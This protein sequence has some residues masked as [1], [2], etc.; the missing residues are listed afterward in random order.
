LTFDAG[1]EEYPSF[2]PDG[3]TLVFDG[4][5]DGDYELTALDLGSGA[6]RRLTHTRGW[7][8]RAVVSP[9]GRW[10][11]YLHTS[12]AGR[13]LRVLPVA[14]DGAAAPRALGLTAS[15]YPAWSRDG[16]I[17]AGDGERLL[18]WSLD[19][20]ARTVLAEAPAGAM[21]RYAAQFAS[22]AEGGP[23]G[24]VVALADLNDIQVEL[25]IAQDDFAKLGAKQ[26]ATVILDAFKDRSYKG[27]I[28]EISPEANRQ[29]A[30][31]QAFL[32]SI[33]EPLKA[34]IHTVCVDMY[35]SYLQA[36]QA[37][38]PQA[39]IVVDRFHVAKQYSE[40]V[41]KV[42]RTEM[43]RLKKTLPK[44]E[45]QTLKGS[46]VVSG[47]RRERAIP[48]PAPARAAIERRMFARPRRIR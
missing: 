19:G 33:P 30:T 23:R 28:A 9:D 32:D 21:I 39:E 27:V 5:T 12:D 45:Y 42:R 20:A 37:A 7:D 22:G 40:T 44:E 2:L 4:V 26:E 6:R 11:A 36:A 3:Q 15:G 43:A 18:R 13:E 29:K 25:D 35:E 1:C 47:K 34:T 14:G 38:L 16:A 31:V 17:L 48:Y 41:D 8:Y 24:S 46:H 10:L